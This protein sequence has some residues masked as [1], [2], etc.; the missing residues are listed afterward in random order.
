MVHTYNEKPTVNASKSHALAIKLEALEKQITF[1][2][3]CHKDLLE[4]QSSVK[5][6]FIIIHIINLL[7]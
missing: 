4:K 7:L 3:K 5:N 6:L 1:F 2:E